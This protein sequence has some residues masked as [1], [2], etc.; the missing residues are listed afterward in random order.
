[1]KTL[2]N[3]EVFKLKQYLSNLKIEISEIKDNRDNPASYIKE[4]LANSKDDFLRTQMEYNG[5]GTTRKFKVFT[6]TENIESKIIKKLK[7]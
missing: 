1:V 4:T 3:D 5:F 2:N 7:L 6:V